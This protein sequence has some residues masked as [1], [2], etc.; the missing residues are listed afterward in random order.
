M[1]SIITVI[2]SILGIYAIS[3]SL[4][5]LDGPFDLFERLRNIH[6]IEKFG[7]LLCIPCISFWVSW[8]AVIFV[9]FYWWAAFGLWGAAI[10][11]D[12]IINEYVVK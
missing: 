9:G 12:R 2:L 4:V 11:I 7:I 8:T 3:Y 5:Y 10:I 1:E 6:F